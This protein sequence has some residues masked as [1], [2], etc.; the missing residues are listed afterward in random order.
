MRQ[1]TRSGRILAIVALAAIGTF[2]TE[3]S[4][5]DPDESAQDAEERLTDQEQRIRE[6]EERIRQL[7]DAAMGPAATPPSTGDTP[8]AAPAPQGGTASESRDPD[9]ADDDPDEFAGDVREPHKLLTSEELVSDQF[10][11]SWPMFGSNMRMKIGGYIKADFVADFDGTLDSTQFLMRTIP[12]AGTPEYGGDPYFD[13]FARESRFNLDIRRV[14]PGAPPLRGF[15][16]GDFFSEGNDFR[17]RHAYITAGNFIAGQTW[18]TLSFLKSLPYMIDFGAGDALFGGRAAQLRY[19]RTLN[20]RWNFSVALEDLQFL[21]I[22]NADGVPGRATSQLPLLALRADY[23][24]DG[25]L[26]LMGTSLGQLHWDGGA[27]GPS[28]SAVQFAVVVAGRQSLG[29]SAYATW[30]V[31]YG[32]G[33][34]ENIIAFAGTEANAV[35]DADGNLDTIPNFSAVFGFGYDWTPALS[36]NLGFAYGWLDTPETRDAFALKR[37]GLSHVNLIW[38]PV[39]AFSTGVEFMWGTTQVQNGSKGRARRLQAMLKFEF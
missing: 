19:Q 32:E 16:E 10:P 33:S 35:L 8:P 20:D 39:E 9:P 1:I 15:I 31:S 6:L 27:A 23:R 21:G 24:Y 28:A 26:L 36:S 13:A 12:V 5:Q 18:T 29:S 7:E 30:N 4:A 17:L 3:V 25:G 22:Q 2:A 11:S 38:K 34:G 37:G 14:M